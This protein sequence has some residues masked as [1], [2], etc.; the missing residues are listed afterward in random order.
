MIKIF[1]SYDLPLEL[2]FDSLE[3]VLLENESFHR[4]FLN[5]IYMNNSIL[6]GC[7][8]RSAELLE[9]QFMYSVFDESKLIMVVSNSDFSHATFK[10]ALLLHS[11]FSHSSFKYADFSQAILNDTNFSNCDFRGAKI[12]CKRLENC[13][14]KN[15]FYDDSTVWPVDFNAEEYGAIKM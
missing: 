10:K 2:E 9:S 11:D 1:R 4:C 8:F 5:H 3:H 13:L 15:A 7:D 14:W 6:I 12:N